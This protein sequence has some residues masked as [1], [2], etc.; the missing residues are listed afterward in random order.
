[1]LAEVI[2]EG[3][4]Y[5]VVHGGVRALTYNKENLYVLYSYNPVTKEAKGLRTH[6][7]GEH[8]EI[9][10][11]HAKDFRKQ[12]E[13]TAE[14]MME[15][16]LGWSSLIAI[17]PNE[18]WVVDIS[19]WDKGIIRTILSCDWDKLGGIHYQKIGRKRKVM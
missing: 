14:Q 17:I 16:N 4:H 12:A 5:T 11:R 6:E 2:D 13:E 9:L 10:E 3:K 18:Y 19:K 15:R 7:W 1:M 8:K